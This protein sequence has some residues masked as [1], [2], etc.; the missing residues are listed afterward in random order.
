MAKTKNQENGK[1]QE[2]MAILVE[3]QAAFVQNQTAF[4][5]HMAETDRINSE[6]FA[7]IETI[8]IQ[9]SQFLAELTHMLRALPEAIREKI[10]FKGSTTAAPVPPA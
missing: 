2:A 7:R 10:G 3:T 8:L 9:H 4:L 1:L 5:A 6:R